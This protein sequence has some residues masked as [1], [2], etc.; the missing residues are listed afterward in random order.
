MTPGHLLPVPIVALRIGYRVL[1]ATPS[2]R[3]T[4]IL[5]RSTF[6]ASER[7]VGSYPPM[8]YTPPGRSRF[9]RG[10]ADDCRLSTKDAPRTRASPH[11][12]M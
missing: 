3:A 4:S 12:N 1:A 8:D 11:K 10:L 7:A 9:S 6:P 5:D 2:W